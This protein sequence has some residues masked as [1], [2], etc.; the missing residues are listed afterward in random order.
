MRINERQGMSGRLPIKLIA[1]S[2]TL[3]LRGEL[4]VGALLAFGF[5]QAMLTP[6][7][8]AEIAFIR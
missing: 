1:S 8:A 3:L 7:V 2:H 6:L 5:V 4:N